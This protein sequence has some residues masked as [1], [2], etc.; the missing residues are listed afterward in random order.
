MIPYVLLIAF[1]VLVRMVSEKYR[2]TVG[3][4]LL[5]ETSTGSIDIFMILFLLLLALRGT[6]CGIDTRQYLRLFNEYSTQSVSRLLSTH[7]HELGYKLLN[8]TVGFA[9]GG[10]QVLLAVTAFVCVYPLWHFYRRES[11]NQL[12]TISLFLSVAPFVMYFSGIRQAMAMSMGVFAWYCARNKRP[13]L[14]AAVI[15]LAMQFHISAFVLVILYPLY[16]LKIT[17]RWLWFVVPCMV[18]V[19]IFKTQLFTFLIAIFWSEGASI[20]RTGATTV[21]MLLILFGIYSY[22]IPDEKSMDKDTI[23]LRNML[24]CSITFQ[25][26]AMLHPWAMRFNYYLLIFIPILIPKIVSQ[27]KKTY[28]QIADISVV[29]MTVYFL[30]NFAMIEFAGNDD[31]NVFPYIPFWKQ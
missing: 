20:Q 21:L 19:Y 18:L 16:H 9:G 15:L 11:E 14:F 2:F 1:P 27:S 10:Y 3:K 8:R 4:K 17:R 13:I 28:K 6:Q 30:Y 24:L 31:L 22:I 5:Y 23:A 12:L 25:F 26:F 7:N 29:I